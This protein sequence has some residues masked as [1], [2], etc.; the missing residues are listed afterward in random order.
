MHVQAKNKSMV[1]G[2]VQRPQYDLNQPFAA[3]E[4]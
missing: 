4:I 1:F 2:I 3:Y